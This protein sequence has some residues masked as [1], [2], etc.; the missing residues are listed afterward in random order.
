MWLCAYGIEDAQTTG[1]CVPHCGLAYV[2]IFKMCLCS[3]THSSCTEVAFAGTPTNRWLI[4]AIFLLIHKCQRGSLWGNDKRLKAFQS[5]LYDSNSQGNI[6]SWAHCPSPL[7]ISL[8]IWVCPH[9]SLS[10]SITVIYTLHQSCFEG[11]I[12]A[13]NLNA[14]AC[15]LI[16]DRDP[17]QVGQPCFPTW[18]NLR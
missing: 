10:I 3:V 16:S 13:Q 12:V 4:A 7:H 2:C 5:L 9:L 17:N 14:R 1:C 18:N 6:R 11:E 15:R 8:I